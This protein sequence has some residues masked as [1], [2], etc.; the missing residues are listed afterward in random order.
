MKRKNDMPVYVLF[1]FS[2]KTGKIDTTLTAINKPMLQLWALQNTIAKT[3]ASAIINRDTGEV[4][5]M[6][7]GTADGFPKVEENCG[8]CEEYGIPLEA[9][10]AIKDDRFDGKEV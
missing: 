1:R 3:K 8:R 7:M 5:Y 6:A 9:L 4:V 10:R 2:K